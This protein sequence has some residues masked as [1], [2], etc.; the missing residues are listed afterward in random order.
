[1]KSKKSLF[2]IL[3][4]FLMKLTAGAQ[5]LSYILIRDE[6]DGN[7]R[8]VQNW[9]RSDEESIRFLLHSAVENVY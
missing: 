1:M 9:L 7:G 2:I 4:V 3:I 5:E 6:P 8:I